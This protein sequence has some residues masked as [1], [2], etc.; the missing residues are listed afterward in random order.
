M[1]DM[2]SI[3]SVGLALVGLATFAVP[4]A[5]VGLGLVA[6]ICGVAC[7]FLAQKSE[8][9]LGLS[10]GGLVLGLAAAAIGAYNTNAAATTPPV[11]AKPETPIT[12]A[13]APVDPAEEE[14]ARNARILAEAKEREEREKA[15]PAPAVEPETKVASAQPKAVPQEQPAPGGLAAG[16]P[17]RQLIEGV[18][19]W[20]KTPGGMKIGDK[21]IKVTAAW[22]SDDPRGSRPDGAG[23]PSTRGVPAVQRIAPEPANKKDEDDGEA[24]DIPGLERKPLIPPKEQINR[25]AELDRPIDAPASA[26]EGAAPQSGKYLCIEVQ[27][28]VAADGK[29]LSL[30]S[31]SAAAKNAVLIDAAGTPIPAAEG[32][33][34][35]AK[36]ATVS[37]G[38]S[39]SQVL[40]FESPEGPVDSLKLA[41]AGSVAGL[42]KPLGFE[43]K[44]NLFGGGTAAAPPR[45]EPAKTPSVTPAPAEPKAEE[46]KP[47]P[48][49]EP[50]PAPADAP[51]PIDENDDR[52]PIPGLID[53]G[54]SPI[55]RA[56]EIKN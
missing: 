13:V 43:I 3:G 4:Y 46:P 52:I 28:L 22:L 50:A 56:P 14:A 32:G 49:P 17:R 12:P 2:L 41:L 19:R 5:P 26:E 18:K 45:V 42:D 53:R 6:A 55:R 36:G 40:V 15:Q 7:F 8:R 9:A 20:A 1:D 39:H 48:A 23:R 54:K 16:D 24:I 25:P 38:G 31:W 30:G 51:P 11:V 34:S 33:G 27:V 37:P 35:R 29:P 21:S 47:E 10:I 44:A